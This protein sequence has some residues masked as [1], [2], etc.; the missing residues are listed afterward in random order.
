M[1]ALTA[2]AVIGAATIADGATRAVLGPVALATGKF[3][4]ADALACLVVGAVEVGL[5]LGLALR[6]PW[7]RST[8][9]AV[10]TVSLARPLARLAR[11]NLL[12][13]PALI[14][15][16]LIVYSLAG[17]RATAAVGTQQ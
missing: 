1:R 15:R 3:S 17:D 7:A 10:A 13:A 9:T 5:G 11:G 4:Q 6:K 16:G 8:A 14:V 2:A 12:A